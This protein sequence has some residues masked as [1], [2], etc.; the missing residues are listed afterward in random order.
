M[1]PLNNWSYPVF[2]LMFMFNFPLLLYQ[3]KATSNSHFSTSK[4]FISIISLPYS[5]TFIDSESKD[6]LTCSRIYLLQV[7]AGVYLLLQ[8]RQYRCPQLAQHLLIPSFLSP[9]ENL[10]SEGGRLL[11]LILI[12]IVNK[13]CKTILILSFW[14][15][16]RLL[17]FIYALSAHWKVNQ[18]IW[19]ICIKCLNN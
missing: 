8:L 14:S 12:I 10:A 17:S 15:L 11:L 7:T 13:H 2:V 5:N 3:Q 1:P 18:V 9:G 19:G 16:H 4:L 6:I